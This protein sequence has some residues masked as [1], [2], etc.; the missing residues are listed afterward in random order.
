MVLVGKSL[1]KW[2]QRG[3]VVAQLSALSPLLQGTGV[4]GAPRL[5]GNARRAGSI[6]DA[7]HRVGPAGSG[8]RAPRRPRIRD[9]R[10]P[11][12]AGRQ[13]REARA[14]AGAGARGR[15]R[16]RAGGAGA[17]G[18]MGPGPPVAWRWLSLISPPIFPIFS[19]QGLTKKERVLY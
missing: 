5:A 4:A 15:G 17:G 8:R 9:G 3:R 18:G 6:W 13:G 12:Q 16:G 11:G 7:R 1:P 10:S 2:G 14:R 19:Y